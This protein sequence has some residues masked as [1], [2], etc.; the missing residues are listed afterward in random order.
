[1]AALKVREHP[2]KTPKS[3]KLKRLGCGRDGLSARSVDQEKDCCNQNQVKSNRQLL[4]HVD[5][6]MH[7]SFFGEILSAINWSITNWLLMG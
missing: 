7:T 4:H 3:G 5:I 1:M 6:R 2:R